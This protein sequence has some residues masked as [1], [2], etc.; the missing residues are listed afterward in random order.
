MPGGWIAINKQQTQ[1]GGHCWGD[2]R[3][4]LITSP[5]ASHESAPLS[6]R[7]SH[8]FSRSYIDGAV[9]L[10]GFYDEYAAAVAVARAEVIRRV[11]PPA[12]ASRAELPGGEGTAATALEAARRPLA[13]GEEGGGAP[14][15][16]TWLQLRPE[17]WVAIIADE[18]PALAAVD[19]A[20][21]R[22]VLRREG[23]AEQSTR[24]RLQAMLSAGFTEDGVAALAWP[25]V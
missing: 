19:L 24:A 4:E 20:A 10:G 23:G 21:L 12:Q 9:C 7:S 6:T 17:T 5:K 8:P 15:L 11:H 22:L 14:A 16:R 18:L 3:N 13:A 1:V 25:A 2:K